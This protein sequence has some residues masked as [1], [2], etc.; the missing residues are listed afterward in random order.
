MANDNEYAKV[1]DQLSEALGKANWFLFCQQAEAQHLK[2][3]AEWEKRYGC[4]WET[5]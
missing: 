4:T 5:R 1:M 2:A 3:K